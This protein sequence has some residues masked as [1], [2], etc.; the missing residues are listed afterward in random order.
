MTDTTPNIAV[1]I[2]AYNED[3][4]I[5]TIIQQT[6]HHIAQVIVIN[7]GSTDNTAEALKD[8][9]I[10]LLHNDTNQGKDKTLLRGFKYCLDNK[11]NAILTIDADGQHDPADIPKFL[12]AYAQ[13]PEHL[14]IGARVTNTENAPKHRLFANKLGDFFVSWAAG[15]RIKDSQSGY[16]LY[17]AA[18]LRDYLKTHKKHDGFVFESEII[19]DGVHNGFHTAIV[20][21][22]SY[23]PEAA[24]ASHFHPLRDSVKIGKMLV[25]KIVMKGFNIPG[26][27]RILK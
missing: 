10:T 6:K 25:K 7:D 17:P 12:D 22:K 15:E 27:I 21:I 5:H 8:L 3:K 14:I 26:L 9:P 19:I 13:H 23:Y 20:P 16:R 11:V 24:R 1:L 4:T 2:P 18:M